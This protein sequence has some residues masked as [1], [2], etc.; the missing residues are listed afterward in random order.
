MLIFVKLAL[1]SRKY[2]VNILTISDFWTP[3]S[4]PH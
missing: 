3:N 2:E 1:S 4:D